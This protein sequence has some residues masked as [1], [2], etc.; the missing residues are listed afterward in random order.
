MA[1]TKISALTAASVMQANEETVIVQGGTDKRCAK[2]V[3]L[4]GGAGENE[5][6]KASAGQDAAIENN[7]NTASVVAQSGGTVLA[8]ATVSINFVANNGGPTEQITIGVGAGITVN[9]DANSVLTL[10]CGVG[11]SIVL[12]GSMNT[13]QIGGFTALTIQYIPAVAGDWNGLAP[14]DIFLAV[15]RCAALLKFLNG[16]V[17]P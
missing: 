13:L 9:P 12:V 10:Q 7:G 5:I 14:T 16:G 1:D 8:S 6:L 3:I 2:S 15:D 17:G 4:T 11:G